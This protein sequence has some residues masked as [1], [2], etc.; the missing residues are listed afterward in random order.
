MSVE[1]IVLS[2]ANALR[3][4]SLA[5]VY[6]LLSTPRPRRLLF[7]F[8]LAGATFSV[9]TGV[10]VV[11]VIN[12]VQ[13]RHG[14]STFD[15]IVSLLAG[16][17][18]IG[19]AAGLAQGRMQLQPREPSTSEGSRI[20][21]T[22]RDPSPAVAATAGVAT[23]LP[24]LFYLVA[25]NAITARDPGLAEG[26]ASVLIFNAIWWIGPIASLVFFM[27]RPEQTRETLAAV[28]AWTRSHNRQI[29][30]AVF[31][32]AGAYLTIKGTVNLLD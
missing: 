1:L 26:I 18:A 17:A 3:P 2:V 12:G 22:L 31:A 30:I 6:A 13:V 14:A 16:V 11:G 4:T 21:R 27:L 25:L 28:N 10:V 20:A 15:A 23:H 32:A 29:L 7:A 19:F 9:V 8:I 5:A 24:G